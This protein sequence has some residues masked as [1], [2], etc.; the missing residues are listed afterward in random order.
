MKCV[1]WRE[2]HEKEGENKN[3]QRENS[4]DRSGHM[5]LNMKK[6]L[7]EPGRNSAI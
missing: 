2:D 6:Q 3:T 7:L 4:R 1:S 5:A